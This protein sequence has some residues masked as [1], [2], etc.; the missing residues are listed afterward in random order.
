MVPE[1]DI[2]WVVGIVLAYYRRR[3]DHIRMGAPTIKRND[4]YEE[5][6]G[7]GDIS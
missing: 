3:L 1:I 2:N 5:L 7:V 6:L 4:S